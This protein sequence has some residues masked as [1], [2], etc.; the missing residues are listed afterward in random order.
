MPG[1]SSGRVLRAT[2]DEL[3]ADGVSL[4]EIER[5]VID[6][7]AMS[8]DSQAALWLYAWGSLERVSAPLAV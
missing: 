2:I 5:D 3:V 6:P 8:E 7:S 1:V 4:A